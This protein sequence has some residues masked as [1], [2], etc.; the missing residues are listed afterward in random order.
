M[1]IFERRLSPQ[2]RDVVAPKLVFYH[3]RFSLNHA[4]HTP[5]QL[6]GSRA[7]CEAMAEMPVI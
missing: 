1:G 6:L 7:G 3:L 5:Q 4:I 2:Q